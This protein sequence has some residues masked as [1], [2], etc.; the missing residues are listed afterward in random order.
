MDA[1]LIA[2]K[3]LIKGGKPVKVRSL[4]TVQ[5]GPWAG[6]PVLAMTDKNGTRDVGG[7]CDICNDKIPSGDAVL[8]SS[9]LLCLKCGTK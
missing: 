8:M 7:I 1:T 4:G 6:L 3:N 9:Y 2:G 5:D